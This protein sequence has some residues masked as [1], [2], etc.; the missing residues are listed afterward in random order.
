MDTNGMVSGLFNSCFSLGYISQQ[1]CIL[2]FSNVLIA[3]E[4]ISLAIVFNFP[5]LS[6]VQLWVECQLTNLALTGQ[7]LVVQFSSYPPYVISCRIPLVYTRPFRFFSFLN[8]LPLEIIFLICIVR[9]LKKVKTIAVQSYNI[10]VL[11]S[12][13]VLNCG[14][15][16]SLVIKKHEKFIP[17]A[18]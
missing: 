8:F 12:H 5:G 2:H 9:V 6:W 17:C 4:L 13:S 15:L 18:Y 3:V 11:H 7:Q 10:I 16:G 14:C 1:H